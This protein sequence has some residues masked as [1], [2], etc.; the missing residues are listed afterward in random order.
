M[1]KAVEFDDSQSIMKDLN[2]LHARSPMPDRDP[3]TSMA[4]P[5][6]TGLAIVRANVLDN[7]GLALRDE[8]SDEED[9]EGGYSPARSAGP[10]DEDEH[11]DGEI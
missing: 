2:M 6:P 7:L 3:A 4:L 5:P 10:T 9:D 8:D 11:E 1:A